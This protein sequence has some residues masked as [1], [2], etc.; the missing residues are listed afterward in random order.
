MITQAIPGDTLFVKNRE[1]TDIGPKHCRGGWGRRGKDDRKKIHWPRWSHDTHDIKIKVERAALPC[2][3]IFVHLQYLYFRYFL[4][5]DMIKDAT[6][7]PDYK[8]HMYTDLH[9]QIPKLIPKKH[10]LL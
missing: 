9:C 5:K 7:H 1:M 10:S 2:C 6:H 3:S 4:L 8:V